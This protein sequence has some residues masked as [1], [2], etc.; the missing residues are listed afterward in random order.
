MHT[1][2]R[3]VFALLTLV[4]ATK[5]QEVSGTLVWKDT[6]PSARAVSGAVLERQM[7]CYP[8]IRRVGDIFLYRFAECTGSASHL[9]SIGLPYDP[10][11][12]KIIPP[13]RGS[14]EATAF[15]KKPNGTIVLY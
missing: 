10:K 15:Y 13:V 5:A 14:A 9:S 4:S 12:G 11:T 1:A 7:H 3:A 2:L 8:T 6:Q